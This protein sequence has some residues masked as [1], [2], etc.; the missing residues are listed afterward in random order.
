MGL[1]DYR[2]ETNPFGM[3]SRV[4]F[5]RKTRQALADE[6]AAV[7]ARGHI[8]AAELRALDYVAGH[9]LDVV[10]AVSARVQHYADRSPYDRPG[11]EAIGD[12]VKVGATR[13]V[14]ETGGM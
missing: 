3:P 8:R 10:G 6:L 5:D 2:R 14:A 4:T 12:A 9:A 13:I 11:F 7:A 1:L